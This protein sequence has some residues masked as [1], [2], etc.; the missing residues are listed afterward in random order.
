MM[1]V[2]PGKTVPDF[3]DG[4][5][6]SRLN[7]VHNPRTDSY[8]TEKSLREGLK[9]DIVSCNA[10]AVVVPHHAP[11][12]VLAVKTLRHLPAEVS[13]LLILFPDHREKGPLLSLSVDDWWTIEGMLSV[14]RETVKFL[15]DKLS[16]AALVS[17]DDLRFEHALTN[18]LPLIKGVVGPEKIVPLAL[19]RGVSIEQ[20]QQLAEVLADL[21]S[22][23]PNIAIVASVDFAHYTAK[24]QA[25]ETNRR[26]FEYLK[27]FDID[28]IRFCGSDCADAP[29]VLAVLLQTMRR[30]G[31][32]RVE[33]VQSAT[34]ADFAPD[35]GDGSTG[36]LGVAFRQ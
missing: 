8:L 31:I 19:R 17:G 12:G 7:F 29:Q 16:F 3:S 11:A 15:L 30:I 4:E 34:S 24:R 28:S 36:Y 10:R 27:N 6:P 22:S 21:L 2:V 23:R 32:D 1:F 9:E 5:K 25:E 13:T 20:T 33:L 18:L 14:D 35:T 26:V